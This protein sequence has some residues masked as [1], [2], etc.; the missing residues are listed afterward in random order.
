MECTAEEL[1]RTVRMSQSERAQHL[2]YVSSTK[3]R[4]SDYMSKVS[5]GRTSCLVSE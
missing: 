4:Q 5:G 3:C 1:W 2:L